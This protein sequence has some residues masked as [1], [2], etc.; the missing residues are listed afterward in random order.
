MGV[1]GA[2][3]GMPPFLQPPWGSSTAGLGS[4][5][6]TCSMNHVS[7]IPCVCVS[8]LEINVSGLGGRPGSP[9]TPD[10]PGLTCW[11]TPRATPWSMCHRQ[12]AHTRTSTCSGSQK[13]LP[14]QMQVPLPPCSKANL[15]T[16]VV[17]KERAVLLQALSQEAK[18]LTL[19]TSAP[20]RL[21]GKGF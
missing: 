6:L 4:W 9:Q 16:W 20:S 11:S 19:R 21:S 18:R 2:Q 17:V 7:G 10:P 13:L 14:I 8:A 3:P 1:Y 15:L 12:G 5:C